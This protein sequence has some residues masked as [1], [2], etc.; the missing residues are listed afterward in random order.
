MIELDSITTMLPKLFRAAL[1]LPALLA[2]GE[3]APPASATPNEL[4]AYWPSADAAALRNLK[5][6]GAGAV[7]TPL[8]ATAP[9]GE[10]GGPRVLAELPADSALDRL[11]ALLQQARAAGFDGAVASAAGN[12]RA[13]RRAMETQGGFLQY[14]YLKPDQLEWDVSPAQ[15]IVQA[16]TWPGLHRTDPGSAGAS[17]RPWLD[18]NLSLY[19][20]LRGLYPQ[21]TPMLSFRPEKDTMQYESVEVALAEAY[22]AGGN[23]VLFIPEQYRE[24]LRRSNA[25]A[26]Q[27]W[28]SLGQTAA[29]LKEHAAIQRQDNG[30]RVGVLSASLDQ[31]E[32]LLNLA[33][34]NNLAPVA[35]PPERLQEE[36]ATGR[37]RVIVA[38]NLPLS[39][40]T[41]SQLM[42]FVSGGG[43]VLTA[44]APEEKERDWWSS[45]GTK[46]TRSE[47][48]YDVYSVGK[49]TLYAYH[50]AIADVA[51]FSLDIREVAGLDNPQGKG[52]HGL[53]FRVWETGTVLGALHRNPGETVLI[54]TAYGG[55][56][57]YDLLVGVRGRFA[58]AT[59]EDVRG[60]GPQ[61]V[62]LM[63]R[64]GRVELDLRGLRR[65]AILVLREK[66]G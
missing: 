5:E 60:G 12:A 53:D 52:L 46:K 19:A 21:R 2:A 10:A 51:E 29:F 42:R 36:L 58:S 34:R 25:R 15:A 56:R 54:L 3:T 59:V 41:T 1:L 57:E 50:E 11:P 16:G 44:P 27:S 8:A 26:M 31:A 28:K 45:G 35:I 55:G 38:A 49:G 9:R 40:A 39:P 24:A 66:Q 64:E 32:E 47:P 30:A 65:L 33:Y 37:F 4:V 20:Y 14:V 43:N 18:A 22:A 23:V 17:E 62:V 48:E 6:I 7:I 63:P 61:P 13:F